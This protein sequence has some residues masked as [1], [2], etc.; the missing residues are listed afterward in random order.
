[1]QRIRQRWEIQKNWQLIFPVLGVTLT[2]LAAY[3]IARRLLHLFG[4]NN[5]YFEWIFT[6]GMTLLL[7]FLLVRLFL[8]CFKKLENKWKV[9]YKWEMI[10]IF[11]VFAITGS[12]AGKMAGPLV[13]WIGLG[14]GTI[15]HVLYW[16]IRI[17]IIFPLYQVL[18]IS[19][20]WLFGQ[21]QFFWNFEKKMLKRMGL[22]F[23]AP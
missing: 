8:W 19:I 15:H 11:I 12:L 9:T 18:L 6:I 1:M 3:M 2:M 4:L 7:Y 13:E 23:L 17:L 10:T 20:G 16:T 5:T 22:G 14:K 21:F